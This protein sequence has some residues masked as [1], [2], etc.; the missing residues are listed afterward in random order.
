MQEGINFGNKI[1]PELERIINN[2]LVSSETNKNLL[3]LYTD[4]LFGI[5]N[6]SN[7]RASIGAYD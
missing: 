1:I 7:S 5:K 6:V 2:I 3:N 4:F